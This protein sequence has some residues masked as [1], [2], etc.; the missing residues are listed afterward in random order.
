[1]TLISAKY[2]SSLQTQCIPSLTHSVFFIFCIAS[3]VICWCN[4]GF[5]AKQYS[6]SPPGCG[7]SLCG[8][9]VKGFVP[10]CCIWLGGRHSGGEEGKWVKEWK[11]VWDKVWKSH[12]KKLSQQ[13][14]PAWSSLPSGPPL[15][16]MQFFSPHNFTSLPYFKMVVAT[17]CCMF[18]SLCLSTI[19]M[20]FQQRPIEWVWGLDLERGRICGCKMK[21]EACSRKGYSSDQKDSQQTAA[22][23][24]H[25]AK[26]CWL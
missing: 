2:T 24:I 11:E 13:V 19:V 12:F 3:W 8:C 17:M 20:F 14:D 15:L 4:G 1:M 6:L 7:P 9:F 25:T 10:K 16:F 18:T 5:V 22:P 26:I 21:T 23:P